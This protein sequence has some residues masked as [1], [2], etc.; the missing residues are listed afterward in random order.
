MKI[1]R[2]ELVIEKGRARQIICLAG[3]NIILTRIT[4]TCI[5]LLI[6]VFYFEPYNITNHNH[7]ILQAYKFYYFIEFS[8]M[9]N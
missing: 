2:T 7:D 1:D 5:S 3:E 6:M 8:R 4:E 9:T